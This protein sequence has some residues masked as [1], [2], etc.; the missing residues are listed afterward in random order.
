MLR[1]IMILFYA[2]LAYLSLPSSGGLTVLVRSSHAYTCN[3]KIGTD[4][5]S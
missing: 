5:V 1:K 2:Y 4:C 3:K